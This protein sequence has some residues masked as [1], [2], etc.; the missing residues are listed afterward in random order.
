MSNESSHFSP[1]A[2]HLF[3]GFTHRSDVGKDAFELLCREHPEHERDLRAMKERWDAIQGTKPF[4]ERLHDRFGDVDPGVSL[5]GDENKA[6]AKDTS[7]VERMRAAG[8]RSRYRLLGE[9]ARGGMGA[10]LKIWDDD[11]RRALAMKVVLSSE[12]ARNGETPPVDPKTLGR[13]L[14]EAQITGQL[15][16]PGIVPVHELGIDSSGR[17]YFT[18]RLVKGEDLRAVFERV[19]AGDLEWNQTRALGVMLKVCEALSY[20]HAKGVIHRDLK[21]GNVMVGKFGEVYVMDWGLARVLGMADKHDLRFQSAPL[22]SVSRVNT[23]WR[24]VREGTPDSPL[25]TMDGDVMGTPSYMA[26]E[27][28]RGDLARLG[29]HSDVYAL[30]AMIYHLIGGEMPYVPRDSR[31]SAR[32]I[33]SALLNGPPRSIAELAPHAPAELIAICEK[34]MHREIASRYSDVGGLASDLRAYLEGRVVRAYETGTWAETKKWVQRNK[35]LASSIA[36]AVLAVAGGAFA[37][38]FKAKEAADARDDLAA[39]NVELSTTNSALEKA[40]SD[41]LLAKDTAEKSARSANAVTEFVRKALISSDPNQAG[42]QS[43]RVVDA[44]DTA[45][46]ELDSGPADMDPE[47]SARLSETIATILNGNAKSEEALHLAERALA[48]RQQLHADDDS[49]VAASLNTVAY[50]LQSLGRNGEALAKYEAA[51]EMLQRLFHGDHPDVA[52]ALNNVAYCLD[53]LGRSGEAL[54]K[55][56]AA[57]EMNQR[58][59]N[60]D[61]PDVAT[62][63]NNVAY[64]LE[65][66]GRSEEALHHYEAA[67]EMRQR[68]FHGDHPDVASSL[69]NIALC[70]QSL[71]RSGEALS[72]YQAALEMRQRLFHGDHPDVAI[73]LNNA[74]WCL[75]S[76]GRSDEALPN[77][78][79]A[80]EMNQRL[81]HG[82]HPEVANNLDNVASC[83]ESLGRSSDALPKQVAALEMRQRLFPADH[84]YVATS[85]N[86]V[87]A[88]LESLGR[89]DEALSKYQAALEMYQRLFHGDHPY[90]AT[91]LGNVAAC[92]ESL[93]RRDEA[94][95]KLEAALEMDQ[96]LFHGDHPDVARSLSNLA[97][98]LESLGRASDAY[99]Y[100]EQASAMAARVLPEGH[101]L[102][103][104][105]LAQLNRLRAALDHAVGK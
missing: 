100:A 75:E 7:L 97:A 6:I 42:N 64:C 1:E 62:S 76:L 74:G 73:S 90:V 98:C 105:S 50:C 21:P 94:L 85:L 8:V 2:E 44:M 28:A 40:K 51:L 71:G 81:F 3:L 38:A 35:P 103:V 48:A 9:V 47:T 58:L 88:C 63:L 101:R 87:A 65:S 102:R 78:E 77:Y 53:A 31:V 56:E 20:A 69:D 13:F 14:E 55:H 82:D 5:A 45:I 41:A 29:P 23:E 66:L 70:L 26:P 49:G 89:H 33:L 52:A 37:F 93:G 83:L 86:N 80:L 27:Q 4:A 12:D 60:G 54:S 59:F 91:S 39:K 99:P 95:P 34:A 96:R 36:A 15:D 57:L 84:P 43:Y 92:L 18:M 11:L 46:K 72:K 79:A 30:G 104:K 25:I 61:H 16:H 32:T 19:H 22:S 10:I 17:V 24:E 68:L 67:F